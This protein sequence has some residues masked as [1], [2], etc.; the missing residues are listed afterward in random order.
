MSAGLY[1]CLHKDLCSA[2]IKICI[3]FN[4]DSHCKIICFKFFNISVKFKATSGHAK[5][6]L[7]LSTRQT[8]VYCKIKEDTSFLQE[9]FI[10][11]INHVYFILNSL[12]T[13]TRVNFYGK[14][15]LFAQKTFVDNKHGSPQWLKF[16]KNWPGNR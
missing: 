6:N 5:C 10:C 16:L 4:T 15:S 11:F 1:T 14:C 8:K 13:S 12:Y 9:N 2:P 3:F 7:E